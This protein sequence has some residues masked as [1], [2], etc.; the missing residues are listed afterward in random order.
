MLYKSTDIVTQS[1]PTSP[2]ARF[3]VVV[4]ATTVT[5]TESWATR[6]HS[7][8]RSRVIGIYRDYGVTLRFMAWA[9]G[10]NT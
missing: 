5:V 3:L 4:T 9:V 7:T 6:T 2:N 1:M 8:R 10:W